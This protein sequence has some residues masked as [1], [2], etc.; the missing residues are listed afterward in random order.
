MVASQN[1]W[2]A[3]DRSTVS[4]RLIPGTGRSVLVRNGAPGDLLLEV[5][6][7]FDREVE[8]V[9]LGADDWGYA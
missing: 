5:A 9:D 8:D 6:A 3:N 2:R 4:S 1:G 7:R